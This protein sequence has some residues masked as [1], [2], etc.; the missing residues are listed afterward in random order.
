MS[1]KRIYKVIFVNQGRL[2]EVYARSVGQGSMLGFVEVEDLAF[3]EK[4]SVVVDPSEESLKT[5]FQGVR[6]F[7]VPMHSIVRI[8]EVDKEG[9]SRVAGKAEATGGN[10]M[11]FP[12]VVDGGSDRNN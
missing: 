1:A 3:G 8:D 10:L 6:R 5:E 12:P 4:T 9:A 2:Y 7:H 11:P